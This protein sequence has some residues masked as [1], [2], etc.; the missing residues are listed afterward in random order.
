MQKVLAK[1]SVKLLKLCIVGLL[2]VFVVVLSGEQ[3]QGIELMILGITPYILYQLY[4]VFQW[5]RKRKKT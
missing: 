4:C 2:L 5:V 1:E 3:L